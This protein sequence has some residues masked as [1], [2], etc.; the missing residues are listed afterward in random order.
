MSACGLVQQFDT[1]LPFAAS[2]VLS[3]LHH[4]MQ[5]RTEQNAQLKESRELRR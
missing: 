2:D 5:G 3:Q 1:W 4:I